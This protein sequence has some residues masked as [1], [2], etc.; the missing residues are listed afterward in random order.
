MN[1]PMTDQELATYLRLTPEEAAIA[2]PKISPE[3]RAVYERM[4]VIEG[5]VDLWQRGLGRR[6]KGVI[7]LRRGEVEEWW[8]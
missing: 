2:L 7:V 8:R 5:E 1:Q 3:R 4:A 6:P